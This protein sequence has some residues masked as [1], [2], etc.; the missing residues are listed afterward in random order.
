MKTSVYPSKEDFRNLSLYQRMI[1]CF[2]SAAL[3]KGRYLDLMNFSKKEFRQ[4]IDPITVEK[5]FKPEHGYT[6]PDG[7]LELSLL[8]KEL[9]ICRLIEN[10][11]LGKKEAEKIISQTTTGL[12]N[13]VTG[14]LSGIFY[15]INKIK[16][17]KKNEVITFRPSYS[18]AES[19]AEQNGFKIIPILTKREDNFLPSFKDIT[20]NANSKTAAIVLVYPN[21]PTFTTFQDKS[22]LK[23]IVDFCQKNEIFLIADNIYQEMM[24]GGEKHV[25]I[26]SLVDNPNYIVKLFG[27]SKD[28]PFF[29]G[30]RLG[31]YVGD[32]KIAEPYFDYCSTN[33][34]CLSTSAKNIFSLDLLFRVLLYKKEDLEFESVD[35]L[36]PFLMGWMQSIN[37]EKIYEKI[38]RSGSFKR[39]KDAVMFNDKK[40]KNNLEFVKKFI[41]RSPVFE[42]I[43]NNDGGNA[44][45]IKI[46]PKYYSGDDLE[47]YEELL[48]RRKIAVYPGNIF[49]MELKENDTWFR[50]TIIHDSKEEIVN[51]LKEVE[52]VCLK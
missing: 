14:V 9:E 7:S 51:L 4:V 8:I 32:P 10:S 1:E 29:T 41:K 40:L 39:Y 27:P 43:V 16:N 44:I 49:G 18:I 36:L 48:I 24:F 23:K 34:V 12:G 20:K 37:K 6:S 15:S 46:N 3:V 28:R 35:L 21:N 52:I 30:H 26:L 33:F 5:I 22:E 47:F 17:P 38:K 13:G 25:E 50:I 19:L 11:G 2:A 42:D 31:Y 45:F